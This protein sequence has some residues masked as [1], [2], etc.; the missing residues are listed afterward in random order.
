[1]QTVA[2]IFRTDRDD[3][4]VALRFGETCC[5]FAELGV[6]SARRANYLLAHRRPGP[7]HVAVLLDNVPEFVYWIGACALA[8]A[9]LVALNP[10]RRGGDLA[11]DVA[12][13]A[14]QL[15]VTEASHRREIDPGPGLTGR[16]LDTDDPQLHAMLEPHGAQAPEVDVSARDT[17]FLI[18][19]S[20]TSGAPKAVI[21][22]H[23]RVLRN[24]L[25]LIERQ[26]LSS[27]DVVYVPM[28]LFH[29]SGLLM[30][31][32]PPL[33]ARGSVLL[34]RRFSASGFLPD[35]RRH[36]VTRFCYVGKPLAYILATPEQPDDARNPL[37]SAF[38]SEAADVDI[39]TF[40]RRFGCQVFD[41][42]G[43]SE[44]CITIVRSPDA[45][46]GSIG[47]AF[48][49][50]IRVM[51]PDTGEECPRAVFDTRRRLV[52]GNEAIGELVN[53]DGARLFEGYWN[54]TDARSER[55]RGD[56]YWSGDLGYRDEQGFFYF[57]G[58][59]SEWL[60]VD[61]E[62]LAATQIEQVL[63]RHPAISVAAAYAV[64]DPLVGDQLMVALELAPGAPLEPGE[65][66]RFLES[67]DDLGS[68]WLPRFVR[69]SAHLPTTATNKVLK[70]QLRR[71]G[72]RCDDPVWWRRE[73]QDPFRPLGAGD[74]AA[75]EAD[76]AARGRSQVLEEGY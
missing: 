70:R 35:V 38:G 18:F 49:D 64:P 76:F 27:A 41:N 63:V 59:S 23:G 55:I 26:A 20:G 10:T 43:S 40:S 54:N 47:T 71:E 57:A 21:Y 73:R 5:T 72:W 32:L 29:S 14:C 52:N 17:C 8:G 16:I 56:A 65:L 45:P 61:G 62:N 22:S 2:D 67:Q 36:G 33:I 31:L 34:R 7:F 11:R 19:T 28:P 4:R 60:R 39:E 74:I 66:R 6:A 3:H 37:R 30:G 13:T 68:K 69:I 42:Y 50:G 24:S 46:R 44:G 1:M 15:L 25:M 12:H 51:N 75:L 48:S 9:T 53:I 58:R